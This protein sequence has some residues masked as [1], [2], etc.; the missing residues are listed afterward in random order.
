[1]SESAEFPSLDAFPAD[2]LWGAATAAYQIEGAVDTDGRSPSIWDTF[3]HTRGATLNGDTGDVACDHYHRWH[4]DFDLAADLTLN[5]YRFSVSWARLQPRGE[6]DLNPL[7]VAHY[8]RQ[9]E[10]LQ[11][12]GIR[13]FVTLYHW[14]MP[15][16]VEDAG[17][18][19]SR[20]T[21]ERFADYAAR[22]VE[23]LGDLAHDWITLNEPWCQAFL[24]YGA[25]VHAPGRQ[26]VPDAV[27]A[28]HHLNLAH[29]LAV[30]AIRAVR[31]DVRVGISNLL[32]DLVP[33]SDD[34]ADVAATRRFDANHNQFFFS[35]LDGGGYPDD[36]LAL[37]PS[38]AD[39]VHDGDARII[40][41]PIDFLGVNHYQQV[42]IGRDESE[43]HLHA[44]SKSAEPALTSLQWSI[45]PESLRNVLVRASSRYPDLPLYITENGACFED[46]VDPNG[47]VIDTERVDYL[48][49]YLAS[50]A[51][52]IKDGV[53]LRGYFAW[54][55]LDNFEW[56]EGYRKRFGLIYVDYGTQTRIP[57]ASAGW[58]R[59]LIGQHRAMVAQR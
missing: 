23:A 53:N 54:S 32:A 21:A 34:D 25:G 4:T 11:D 27:A 50:A 55:L 2:F 26:S 44:W 36:V 17:G 5:A 30:Q 20:R 38:L 49:Q 1:M 18:W 56:G 51:N 16:V 14:D 35:P 42:I 48:R 43:P 29:G 40:G 7:A 59:D 13:P 19:P 47:T 41:E 28:A 39:L 24:G 45:R 57:K 8:R 58:Y 6:G 52:A 3:S 10:R 12:L 22:T 46:Y 33:A 37:Y 31:T 9:L 15:Q